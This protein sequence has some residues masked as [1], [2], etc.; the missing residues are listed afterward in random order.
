MRGAGST[1]DRQFDFSE[2]LALINGNVAGDL[3][4][5]V[6]FDGVLDFTVFWDASDFAPP[7]KDSVSLQ[8]HQ[9]KADLEILADTIELE[10]KIGMLRGAIIDTG[11]ID[12]PGDFNSY[13]HATAGFDFD[14]YGGEPIL[15]DALPGLTVGQH[16]LLTVTC[17]LDGVLF[18]EAELGGQKLIDNSWVSLGL[19]TAKLIAPNAPLALGDFT[20]DTIFDLVINGNDSGNPPTS[21]TIRVTLPQAATEGSDNLTTLAQALDQAIRD[22]LSEAGPEGAESEHLDKVRAVAIGGRLAIVGQGNSIEH[23]QINQVGELG[24]NLGLEQLGFEDGQAVEMPESLQ[25]KLEG[26]LRE[27]YEQLK[28]LDPRQLADAA[29]QLGQWLSNLTATD[30]FSGQL[31]LGGGSFGDFADLGA[32]MQ[33]LLLGKLLELQ[34]TADEPPTDLGDFAQDIRFRLTVDD[35]DHT[36]TLPASVTRDNS[37]LRDLAADLES[38]IATVLNETDQAGLIAVEA[39]QAQNRLALRTTQPGVRS[40]RVSD[41]TSDDDE[42]ILF[43]IE[44]LGFSDGQSVDRIRLE[45]LQDLE[46]IFYEA[47]T[48]MGIETQRRLLA[49]SE[50]QEIKDYDQDV[51]FLLA[52]N[53]AKPF[54]V[55]LAQS[56]TVGN[57]NLDDLASDLT[58]A[59]HNSF[60]AEHPV[61]KS[62]LQVVA[63]E[64]RLAVV[65]PGLSIRSLRLLNVDA[66]EGSESTYGLERLGFSDGQSQL[67]NVIN[68]RERI[69]GVRSGNRP[70]HF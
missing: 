17:D 1:G 6:G 13:I 24:D 62:L 61:A 8:L 43:G 4:A 5:A 9:F 15:V 55:T 29:Q 47:L 2:A 25:A 65:S 50:P 70:D 46:Q 53:Q 34:L 39:L 59:I 35:R 38:S 33:E 37:S 14:F 23:L 12:D 19:Y 3:S 45:T 69:V 10:A 64:G 18:F 48:G 31:P 36:I 21:Q 32:A 16:Y 26:R 56:E 63:I 28:H 68:G 41:L 67:V 58:A 44:R 51:K 42:P 11:T 22:A 7:H 27:Y 20:A 30:L 52:I 54:E 49:D 57:Q 40:L 66:S 60:P